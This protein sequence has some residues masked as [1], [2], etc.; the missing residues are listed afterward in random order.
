MNIL[1]LNSS[2][3]LTEVLWTGS[4]DTPFLSSLPF[5]S[6]YCGLLDVQ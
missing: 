6:M 2:K 4:L 1:P 3:A 5:S